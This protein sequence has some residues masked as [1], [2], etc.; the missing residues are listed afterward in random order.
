MFGQALR[1]LLGSSVANYGKAFNLPEMNI[2]ERIVGKASA[3]GPA[4]KV[5]GVST[6]Q[7][8]PRQDLFSGI[9]AKPQTGTPTY[10]AST[11]GQSAGAGGGGII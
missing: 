5:Q 7:S 2:S 8:A 11:G 3:A 10:V 9:L 6:Q 4:P 1:N